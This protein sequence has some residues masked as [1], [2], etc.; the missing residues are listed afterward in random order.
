MTIVGNSLVHRAMLSAIYLQ[1]NA[2]IGEF[3]YKGLYSEAVTTFQEMTQSFSRPD[4]M[5]IVSAL[6]ACAELGRFHQEN[7]F[8]LDIEDQNDPS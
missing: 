5:T 1:G 3:V 2:M 4:G 8:T 7:I 6:L